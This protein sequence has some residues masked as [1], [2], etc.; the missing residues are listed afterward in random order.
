MT[1]KERVLENQLSAKPFD[2]NLFECCGGE[3]EGRELL[4][5]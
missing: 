1:P 4:F 5:V 2:L 3:A